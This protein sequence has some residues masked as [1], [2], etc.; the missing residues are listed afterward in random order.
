MTA[1]I[2]M[3]PENEATG[4]L[5]KLYDARPHDSLSQCLTSR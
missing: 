4:V 1:W 5:K 2:K 3:I